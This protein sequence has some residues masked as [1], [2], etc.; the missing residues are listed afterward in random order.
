MGIGVVGGAFGGAF[1]AIEIEGDVLIGD[2]EAALAVEVDAGGFDGGQG[3]RRVAAGGNVEGDFGFARR[4]KLLV[5]VAG[6]RLRDR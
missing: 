5:G 4:I 6:K 2:G 1:A 3:M